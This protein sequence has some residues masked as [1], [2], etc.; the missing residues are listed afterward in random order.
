MIEEKVVKGFRLSKK[1]I[2]ELERLAKEDRRK[3]GTYVTLV[4]EDHVQQKG[5]V[6]K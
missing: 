3:F 2:A 5:K 4:L 1:L 6:K